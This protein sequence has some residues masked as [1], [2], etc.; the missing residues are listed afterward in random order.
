MQL[1]PSISSACLIDC[2]RLLA[3][4]S[5]A[6][7]SNAEVARRLGKHKTTIFTWKEGISEPGY[8]DGLRLIQIHA[9]VMQ[10]FR[11]SDRT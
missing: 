8:S 9:Y 6:G 7:I 11:K 2:F 1:P 10:S 5:E 3:D 4:L